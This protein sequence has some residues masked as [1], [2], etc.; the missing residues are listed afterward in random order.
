LKRIEQMISPMFGAV[1]K[2]ENG[3]IS[4]P[5]ILARNTNLLLRQLGLNL[6]LRNRH[7]S[8]QLEVAWIDHRGR[9]I[10]CC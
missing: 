8:Y 2:N 10:P 9:Q 1:V 4:F 6:G 5:V 7:S 3:I